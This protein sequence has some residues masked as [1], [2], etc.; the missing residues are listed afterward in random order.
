MRKFTRLLI[1]EWQTTLQYRADLIMWVIMETASPLVSLAIWYTIA[2]S[3]NSGPTPKEVRTYYLLMFFIII[4]TSAWNG[5]FLSQEI[6]NGTISQYLIRPVSV[7][8]KHI[9]NNLTE[10][11]IKLL[12]PLPIFIITLALAPHWFSETIYKPLNIAIF[13]VSLL[14]GATL[15]FI[16]DLNFGLL[17]FWLEDVTQIRR[18]NDLLREITSGILIPFAFLPLWA[19]NLFSFLPFRYIYSAPAEIILEQAKGIEVI[20]LLGV[21]AIYLLLATG[22]LTLLWR[23]GIKTYVP[24]GN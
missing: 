24:V 10:K 4:C 7:F 14:L 17:A 22:L 13:I 1:M 19:H 18:Y 5:F 8:S 12:I 6:L 3:A 20:Q 21:Q 2:S 9:A 15:S 23:Q 11:I 16:I